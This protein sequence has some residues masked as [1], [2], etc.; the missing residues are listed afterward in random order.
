MAHPLPEVQALLERMA[1]RPPIDL[2][3]PLD[4]LRLWGDGGV[5]MNQ[6]LVRDH[7][8]LHSVVDLTVDG[9]PVRVYVPTD[10]GELPVHVHVHGGG[11]WMGS[12]ATA[13]PMCRELAHRT[14]MAV[15]S[16]GYRL[17]PEHPFPAGLDDVCAAVRWVASR[18]EALGF[19][20]TTVSL[21]GESAGGNLTAA[22]ALRLRDEGGPA[23]VATW[24]DIPAVDLTAPQDE[25]MAAFGTGYG[26]E[27]TQLALLVSWYCGD[28]QVTHPW[29]S[30][31]LADNLTGLPPTIVTTA[32]LD[33]IR[34]QAE[35]YA[36]ALAAAGNEVV[37]RRWVGHVHASQWFTALTPG[38]AEAYEEVV[39]LLVAHHARV[40]A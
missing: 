26:L 16:V 36:A 18:P 21:G 39:Q 9:V 31:A 28:E 34:D 17:A 20:P 11:W 12:I 35:R 3:A 40:P 2:T 5:L 6:H 29:V 33:P 7:G 22:A 19:T 4:E 13:D 8:P 23:L 30:P 10:A 15:V 37:T 32:E 14:G 1:T 25:S 24:L 27:M 38:T